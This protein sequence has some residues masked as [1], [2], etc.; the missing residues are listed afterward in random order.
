MRWA[1]GIRLR[2]FDAVE[3]AP[4]RIAM[5]SG[6][7]N[8]STAL[9]RSFEARGDCVVVDEPLYAAYLAATGL[10]HPGREDV[11][12][13][14]PTDWREVA[15]A[16]DGPV[17]AGAAVLYV[18]H[19]AHHLLPDVGRAWLRGWRHAFLV[20][21]PAAVV[22]SLAKVL[23]YPPTLEDT[24]LPQ[25]LELRRRFGGP[26]VDADDVLRDAAATL[27]RLCGELEIP[28][29]ERMLRWDAGRRESDG[30]WAPHWYAA[31]EASTGFG[32]APP[33]HAPPTDVPPPL[34]PLVDA[35]R[36]LYDALRAGQ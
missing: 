31:V 34:Q 35:C 32:P 13:S 22:V 27:A 24:G 20:R 30:V 3:G 29:T 18:K 1:A 17:G 16:L 15:A 9:M 21:D 2:R 11:L 4:A 33:A 6:P 7:R 12:A 23:P 14:Q 10:E 8:L 36:P 25:Q 19:M 28:W 5:W 26:V